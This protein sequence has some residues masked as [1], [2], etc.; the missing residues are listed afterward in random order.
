LWK[1]FWEIEDE[2]D[3]DEELIEKELDTWYFFGSIW[4]GVSKQ[5]TSLIYLSDSYG[6]LGGFIVDFTNDIPLKEVI[7]IGT[8]L[9]R[10]G[11]K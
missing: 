4:R 9:Y 2:H 10:R 8:I 3:L 7:A 11:Y 5:T 6:T 1:S